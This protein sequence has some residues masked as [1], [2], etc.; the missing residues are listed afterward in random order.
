MLPKQ[1]IHVPIARLNV[2]RSNTHTKILGL[3]AVF[4]IILTHSGSWS[5]LSV[6][7]GKLDIPPKEQGEILAMGTMFS[8]VGALLASVVSLR[9]HKKTLIILAM[10]A[11]GGVITLLFTTENQ[12]LY[13]I[14]VSLFMLFWN[15][16]LPLFMG[17]IS[18][19]DQHGDTIRLSVA[20][21]TIGAVLG[22]YILLKDW[23]LLELVCF[24]A[25]TLLCIFPL[26]SQR[27]TR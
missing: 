24:L 14:A 11:Q 26:L 27:E 21:Q 20:A 19:K 25:I 10:F 16:L 7:G 13:F 12:L 4:M 18:E 6:V 15:F 1:E 2:D 22:P 23:I 3:A 8:L 17:T 9:H 5:M